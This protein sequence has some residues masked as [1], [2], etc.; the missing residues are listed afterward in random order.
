MWALSMRGQTCQRVL[1]MTVYMSVAMA[2]VSKVVEARCFGAL[3]L[4]VSAL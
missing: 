4:L 1:R 3:R 2:E